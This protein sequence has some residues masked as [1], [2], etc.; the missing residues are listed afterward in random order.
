MFGL[1]MGAL[2]RRLTIET[3][4]CR[5]W[6][7][8]SIR[9]PPNPHQTTEEPDFYSTGGFHPVFFLGTLSTLAHTKR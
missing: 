3:R 2:T 7:L 8:I 6:E 5:V 9:D 1:R 4:D